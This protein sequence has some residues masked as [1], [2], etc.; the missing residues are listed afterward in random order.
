MLSREFFQRHRRVSAYWKQ[1][2]AHGILGR[3][4]RHPKAVG[5][6]GYR[7]SNREY[8]FGFGAGEQE[9]KALE[10]RFKHWS[11]G[12]KGEILHGDEQ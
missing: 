6:V 5:E 9:R 10:R 8:N 3:P 12:V 11:N 7:K 2:F 1:G 4:L